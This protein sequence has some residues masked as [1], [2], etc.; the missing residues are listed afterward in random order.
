MAEPV[1][2]TRLMASK[3]WERWH[4]KDATNDAI[5]AVAT[6]RTFVAAKLTK[7][8]AREAFRDFVGDDGECVFYPSPEEIWLA[9]L[10][11]LGALVE[12]GG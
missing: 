8:Q 1:I 2:L 5:Y 10:R 12:K 3:L 7:A 9:A 4:H 6:G 11:H